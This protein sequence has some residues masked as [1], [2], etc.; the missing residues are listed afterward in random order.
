MKICET[1]GRVSKK[2]QRKVCYTCYDRMYR[3]DNPMSIKVCISC[4][5]TCQKRS[6]NKEL[7]RSCYSKDYE[8]KPER[9]EKRKKV[10]AAL[11][12]SKKGLPEDAILKPRPSK[13]SCGEGWINGNGYALLYKP[14]HP[15]AM[16]NGQICEHAL[17]MSEMLG[18]P[19]KK[20][21]SVHHKNGIRDDNRIDNLELWHKGQPSGQ[22][23]DDKIKW[24]K[25]F[26]E[27]YGYTIKKS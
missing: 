8:K 10:S 3:R 7:C 13:R 20:F 15:N 1:C 12:R 14:L 17:I 21:E 18:R 23:L 9:I 25:E 22:R 19:L 5:I 26:L 16:K 6:G 11:R 2:L 24:A 27:E 4:G